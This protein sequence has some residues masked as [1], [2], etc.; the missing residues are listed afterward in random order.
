MRDQDGP[1]VFASNRYGNGYRQLSSIHQFS[2]LQQLWSLT[3]GKCVMCSPRFVRDWKA[4]C[5]SNWVSL[6][7]CLCASRYT[8][9]QWILYN[10]W[11]V[12]MPVF[13]LCVCAYSEQILKGTFVTDKHVQTC[14]QRCYNGMYRIQFY[15]KKQHRCTTDYS[16][17]LNCTGVDRKGSYQNGSTTKGS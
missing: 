5:R 12:S 16:H 15:S 10:K 2:L 3:K 14:Q 17:Q 9:I 13:L 11:N 4:M 6:H 7:W 8:R 1:W